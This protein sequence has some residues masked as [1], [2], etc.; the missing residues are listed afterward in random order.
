MYDGIKQA[1]GPTKKLTFPLESAAREILH[2]RDEQLG[3]WVQH[4]FLL[5]SRRNVVNDAFL[6]GKSAN[7]V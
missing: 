4:F 3:R 7:D 2:N 1:A 6:H 5:Y